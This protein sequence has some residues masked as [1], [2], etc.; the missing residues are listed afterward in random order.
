MAPEAAEKR[1]EI[2]KKPERRFP[3]NSRRQKGKS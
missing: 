1:T 3:P 2:T